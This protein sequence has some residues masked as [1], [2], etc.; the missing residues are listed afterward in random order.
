VALK[1][2]ARSA[3][4]L[5]VMLVSISL[6]TITVDY[7]EGT[8]G[9][10]AGLGRTALTIISPMQEAVSRIIRPIGNFF[11][12]LVHLPQIRAENERLKQENEQLREQNVSA[13]AKDQQIEELQ[14]LLALQQSSKLPE[15]G[16]TVIANGPSNFEWSITIDKGSG[17]G[18]KVGMPIVAEAGLV[19]HVMSVEPSS[20]VVQLVLDP[21]SEVTARLVDSRDTGILEGRGEGDLRMGLVDP[22]AVVTSGEEV[23]T[24]GYR[25]PG[26]QSGLYPPDIVVGTVSRVLESDAALEK[27]VLVRPA[28]DFSSLEDVLVVLTSGAG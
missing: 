11:S 20:A 6:A 10:L 4:L 1:S 27:F 26:G 14:S 8:S 24:A 2:T 9:P 7:R 22:A 3:R 28:V 13:A 19:G 5:V 18:V 25:L 12:T 23:V 21:N 17:D 15:I 16:A